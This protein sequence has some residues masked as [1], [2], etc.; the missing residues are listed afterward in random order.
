MRS[1]VRNW[2][3]DAARCKIGLKSLPSDN[4]FV[5]PRPGHR[6]VELTGRGDYIQPSI[7]SIKLRNTRPAL[8]SNDLFDIVVI[9]GGP[10]WETLS[11]RST[12]CL[13]VCHSQ[14]RPQSQF[15]PSQ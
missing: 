12:P 8:R 6:T 5:G 3:P 7:Q 2:P 1:L 4:I 15:R 9:K 11:V 10:G 14:R 13:D